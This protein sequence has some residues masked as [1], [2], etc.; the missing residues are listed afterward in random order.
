MADHDGVYAWSTQLDDWLKDAKRAADRKGDAFAGIIFDIKTP[1]NLVNLR[2]LVRA[3]L[4][5][6]LNVIYGIAKYN[7]RDKLK[8]LFGDTRSNEGYAIDEDNY[9]QRVQRFFK[10]HGVNNFWY[11]NGILVAGIGPNVRASLVEA[12]KER[13]N[14]SGIKKTYV[15]T[16][17][18]DSS[19]LDYFKNVKVDG[20][21]V[22]E[23]TLEDARRIA[24]DAGNRIAGRNDAA[25]G[26]F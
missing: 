19:I 15:W 4:P 2:S 22:N 13:D 5:N 26:V 14:N 12:A 6:N 25:F 20:V 21:M 1:T 7:D 24:M 17:A 18:S 23:S 11:G 9:P 3:R 16:L 8:V 10:S